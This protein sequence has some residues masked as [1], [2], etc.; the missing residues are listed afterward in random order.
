MM[1][2]AQ[3]KISQ[4]RYGPIDRCQVCSSRELTSVL[5]VGY[6]PPVNR[7]RPI[8]RMLDE[9]PWFPAEMLYCG[10]CHLVQLGYA[11]DPNIL[12]PPDYPY[13]SGTTRILRE[14]FA[15]L[16]REVKELVGL[17]PGD[18]TV[19]IGSNDG[20]L[21]SNFKEG[22]YPVCGVEPSL[23]AKMAEE[24]GIPTLMRF[25]EREAVEA[26]KAE[27]GQPKIVTAT[28]VFAHIH[29]VNELMD[30]I[31]SLAGPEG[32]FISESHYLKDLIDTLQ[33]DTIYHEHL[34]YYSLTSL[35]FL[36][37]SRGFRIFHVKRIPTH[38][39]S[40]RVYASK[41]KRYTLRGSVESLL[42]EEQQAGLTGPS[43]IPSFRR[44]VIESKLKLYDLLYDLKRQGNAIYGIGAPSRASTLINYVGLDDGILDC[45]LEVKGSKKTDKYMPGTK[46]PVL[47]ESKLYADQPPYALFLSWH[48]SWELSRNLAQRGYTGDF[49]TPLP[50]PEILPNANRTGRRTGASPALQTRL[51]KGFCVWFTGLSGAGKT[52]I[53]QRLESLLRCNGQTVTMLDGDVVRTHLSKGL[54]Y[55]K[56]DRDANIR[57]IGFVAS[58]IV[59]HRGI[60][61]CAAISPYRSVRDECRRMIGPEQF[62]EVF[63][64]TP[65]EI[66]EKRDTKGMYAKAR[67]GEIK[68]F[69][70]VDDPYEPPLKP[71][72]TLTTTDSTP[73][74]DARR[75]LR[76]LQERGFVTAG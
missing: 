23:T 11:V 47:E 12:F 37:E 30:N 68:Q 28:N 9:E 32:V 21:L 57:R 3:E 39:G 2:S 7:M 29:R 26:V 76:F 35:K 55:S 17:N 38:G 66:C 22:G 16:F 36:L 34:R 70:G 13:T 52:S 14:N 58:E 5:F 61:V 65:L 62:I 67:R 24:R 72:I 15:D 27:H 44:R 59:R 46:I 6:L 1:T 69:T 54:G 10:R 51:E 4:L 63:V 8:G 18:L 53:A 43:W 71:E 49:I 74:E 40:I 45:V 73:E 48:I 64:D 75:V 33:Y 42:K 41:S 60:A 50:E 20:T 56:E 25:F 19:D 31:E